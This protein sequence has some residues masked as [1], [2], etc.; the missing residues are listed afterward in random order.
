MNTTS[1]RDATEEVLSGLPDLVLYEP[2]SLINNTVGVPEDQNEN[3]FRMAHKLAT[4]NTNYKL[5]FI[6]RESLK[7]NIEAKNNELAQLV[8]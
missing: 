8:K 3:E 1:H 6:E 7:E 5:K 4:K 2:F